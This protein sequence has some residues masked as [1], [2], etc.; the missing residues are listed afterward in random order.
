MRYKRKRAGCSEMG[1]NSTHESQGFV[2]KVRLNRLIV[3]KHK[4]LIQL[5]LR[6]GLSLPFDVLRVP[7]TNA[8]VWKRGWVCGSISNLRAILS[9]VASCPVFVTQLQTEQVETAVNVTN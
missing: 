7:G 1:R 9:L 8:L 3:K 5:R 6:R 4:L 2:F